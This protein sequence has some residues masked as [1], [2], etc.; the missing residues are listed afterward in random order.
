MTVWSPWTAFSLDDSRRRWSWA[1]IRTEAAGSSKYF[2]QMLGFQSRSPKRLIHRISSLRMKNNFWTDSFEGETQ[3]RTEIELVL[4]VVQLWFLPRVRGH[5]LR[6][7]SYTPVYS[8][9]ADRLQ[10]SQSF[11]QPDT[12][13]LLLIRRWC[14]YMTLENTSLVTVEQEI[15]SQSAWGLVFRFPPLTPSSLQLLP[16]DDSYLRF[17]TNS[18]GVH[19]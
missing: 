2:Y 10:W 14:D 19:L 8:W 16:S 13:R 9:Y 12:I 7:Q 1:T 3:T 6:I 17:R 4:T 18:S 11:V 5:Y 15:T